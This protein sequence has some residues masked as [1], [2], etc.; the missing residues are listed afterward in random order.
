MGL[1]DQGHCPI[2]PFSALPIVLRG[3]SLFGHGGR[4]TVIR[5]K[6]RRAPDLALLLRELRDRGETIDGI[7]ARL[8]LMEIE[9]ARGKG[10]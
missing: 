10:V 5:E 4:D 2:A 3:L 7:A 9:T 6:A 8:T 1:L